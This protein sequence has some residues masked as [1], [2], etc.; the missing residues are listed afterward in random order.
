MF[1]RAALGLLA[2]LATQT[3]GLGLAGGG[4]GWDAPALF[5]L[6][7]LLLYP[8]VFVRAFSKKGGIALGS[9]ILLIA[10]AL[11]LCLL[12]SVYREERYF[13]T[14][15]NI[16]AGWVIA[17]LALWAAW[18]ALA[19]AALLKKRAVRIDAENA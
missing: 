16:D 7:L 17:W 3:V 10:V 12:A 13:S 14:M 6:P 5:S 18:Q 1:V 4:H 19:V 2:W 15:W 8:V 9:S 11:D